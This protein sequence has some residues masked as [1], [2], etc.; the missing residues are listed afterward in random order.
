M[1]SRHRLWCWC[2]AWLVLVAVSAS[3]SAQGTTSRVTGSV[4]DETGALIP[5]ATVTLTN[6]DT[7]VS[8]TTV[9]TDAGAYSFEAVQVGSYSLKVE[10]SGFKVF[11]STA[12][13]VA[14]GT[15]TTIN[16]RLSAG[17]VSETIEVVST[18]PAVQVSDSGNYGSV[19]DQKSVES[20]PIIGGRG[21]NP[22]E[23]VRTQ[24]GV[25]SGANTGGGTHVHGARDRAWNFTLDGIDVNESSAGGSNFA[26]F[27]TNPDSIS[28]FKILTGNFTA[29]YGRNSGGQVAMISRSGT[30]DLH[31]TGFY[32]ARRPDFNANEWENNAQRL[33]KR[34]EDI[35]I[36][37]FSLGGPIRRNKTFFF[38]NLQI[39][40]ANREITVTRTVY[41]QQAR[42]GI[43]RY[44]TA[45]RTQPFGVTG[46][47]V[48]ASGNP[49]VP[50]ATY[51]IVANDPQGIG[52]DAMTQAVIAKTPLP[53]NFTAGDGLNRAGYTWKPIEEEKQYD[54]LARVDQVLGS[55][56]YAFGRVGIGEQNTYCDDV[57]GGLAPFEG[58]SC[59]VDTTRDPINIAGSWRW[60]P[61]S[62]I[63][64]ELVVGGNHFTFDFITPEA[65]PGLVDLSFGG[66]TMPQ[67]FQLGNARTINTYQFVNN[68]TYVRGAHTFKGG[69]N[70]RYQQHKDV[71]GSVGSANANPIINFDRNVNTVSTTGFNIPSNIQQANDL[72]ALQDSINFLLGR[73][74]S[75]SQ[76]FVAASGNTWAPGGTNF[77]FDA[78][79]PELDLFVQD[80]WK[81]RS[82]IT[83][84]L[85]LRWEVKYAPRDPEDLTARPNAR[86]AVGEAP[87]S[88]LTWVNQPLYDTDYNNFG[89]SVGIAWDPGN[90]GKSVVRGNYRIAYDRI[91]TFLFSSVVY[92]SIPGLTYTQ[93]NT[94]FGQGG[95]R[96]PNAPSVAPPGSPSDL[97][98]PALNS[99]SSIHVVDPEWQTPLTHGWALSYQREL[100]SKMVAEVAYIGR[101]AN[102][103]YGAYNVN[104]AEIR[105]NGF[106]D[107]FNTVKAGGQSALI[108]Q[109]M[110]PDM[111][112][113][114][115]E[116]GSDAMRRLYSSELTLNSVAAVAQ[117]LATRVQGGRTLAELAGLSP[118]FFYNYPQFLGGM[119]VLD[120]NDHSDYHAL[121]LTLQRRFSGG[122]GYMF[123]YT[124]SRSRDTRSFDPAFTR[125]STGSV[126]SA[127]STPF[128]IYDRDLNFAPSDFDRRHVVQASFVTEL[129]IGR[130]RRFGSDMS[131]IL[132]AVIGG[133]QIAGIAVIQTGR[134][135]TVY[136][137]SNT[138]SN[139]VQSP[140]NCSGCD[141]SEGAV[142]DDPTGFKFYFD[143]DERG[144]F[145]TPAAGQLGNAGRNAFISPNSFRL[146]MTLSKSFSLFGS[147][148]LEV[149]AD[150]TNLTN[151]PTFSFPTAVTTSPTFGRIG[152]SVDSGSRKVQLGLKYTF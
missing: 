36:G 53:N 65:A 15:T 137:G 120:T 138:F 131:P 133:W 35:N 47:S 107:A 144:M 149:R 121:E 89:P 24:P 31:G 140:A 99:T 78:R 143:A 34:A 93:T 112:R 51:N 76:G 67:G 111:R 48:D 69:V 49:I 60:N 45:G 115:T 125:V 46:A 98:T 135:F 81:L 102:T 44:S 52:L 119:N 8:F 7:G 90:D 122:F 33:S 70:F 92:Q 32:F 105:N 80:N 12:N 63:V 114:A 151:T 84:D 62:S 11:V 101:K 28:E 100:W 118:Y 148:S 72:P 1:T 40:R 4:I 66:I 130:E 88:A 106:L 134:P 86:V 71:R 27:R 29:E 87:N 73:V 18:A 85:G 22:L 61:G 79:F 25:V 116:T 145:S 94:T 126:Q 152:F 10:I 83:V 30:N 139:V 110:G 136:G 75:I 141:G 57:N 39:L 50:I 146:D 109:L 54:F 21:R 68:T 129:P 150:T 55:R 97:T 23:L 104:Q 19:I 91:A 16:A 20:L 3:L 56:H 42:Q 41:T 59:L 124:L 26:P 77:V 2:T 95:G 37:G 64:N 6:D 9:T 43:W 123:G 132:D 82:N 38:T 127:S 117:G 14:I 128:D 74:G 58:L 147:H 142:F 96:L 108:N 5:G 13:R 113:T 17:D 103:L